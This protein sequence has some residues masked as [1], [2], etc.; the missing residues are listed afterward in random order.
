[1]RQ[2]LSTRNM[3]LEVQQNLPASSSH[4]LGKPSLGENIGILDKNCEVKK[5]NEETGPLSHEM[6]IQSGFGL[7]RLIIP[8]T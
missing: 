6:L 1:M 4:I 8:S 5:K 3:R 2:M 7:E